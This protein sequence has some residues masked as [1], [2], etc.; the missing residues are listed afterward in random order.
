MIPLDGGMIPP[1]TCHHTDSSTC[2]KQFYLH[3]LHISTTTYTS[4][5]Y[6]FRVPIFPTPDSW[7]IG[8][9]ELTCGELAEP[10]EARPP[11]LLTTGNFSKFPEKSPTQQ[12]QRLQPSPLPMSPRP[13]LSLRFVPLPHFP[14]VLSLSKQHPQ[15]SSRH[16]PYA[17]RSP[18]TGIRIP[19]GFQAPLLKRITIRHPC[20]APPI[21][22]PI[23][24]CAESVQSGHV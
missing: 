18:P 3:Y 11:R 4:T 20:T 10:A 22:C 5:C 21:W 24:G 16:T 23:H 9:A 2:V 15:Q 6:A 19:P 8:H 7:P 17:V 14:P 1:D 12:L 13:Q